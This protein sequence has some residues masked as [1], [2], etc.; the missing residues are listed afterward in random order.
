LLL[1]RVQVLYTFALKYQ[2][3]PDW[4]ESFN[5]ISDEIF[6]RRR[7]NGDV[8]ESFNCGKTQGRR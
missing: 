8:L 5:R 4:W 3:V 7:S 2:F 6:P 1:G